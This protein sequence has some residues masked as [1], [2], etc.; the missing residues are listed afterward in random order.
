MAFNWRKAWLR[1]AA[2]A[3]LAAVAPAAAPAQ[4]NLELQ[5]FMGYKFGGTLHPGGDDPALPYASIQSSR[6]QGASATVTVAGA[7]KWMAGGE[8]AWNSQ[9]ARA[10]VTDGSVPGNPALRIDQFLLHGLIGRAEG[11]SLRKPLPFALF[12][13]G[14]T[15]MSGFARF[16]NRYAFSF[17]G[18]VRYFFARRFGLRLQGRFSP[19]HL[20]DSSQT[21]T[22]VYEPGT[23]AGTTRDVAKYFNQ[24]EFTLGFILRLF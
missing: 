2:W 23:P 20:Y 8:L 5:P 21:Y 22:V 6:V 7:T 15:R 19:V 10:K 14:L 18:G 24:G 9:P 1:P 16:N 4:V 12:G 3:V 11:K 13:A 17:G